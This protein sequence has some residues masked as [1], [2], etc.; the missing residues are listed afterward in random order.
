MRRAGM[1]IFPFAFAGLIAASAALADATAQTS[2]ANVVVTSIPAGRL[3][4]ALLMLAAEADVSIAFDATLIGERRTRG[5]ATPVPLRQALDQLLSGTGLMYKFSAQGDVSVLAAPRPLE[6]LSAPPAVFD[7]SLSSDT[8]IVTGYR[9]GLD[10]AEARKRRYDGLVEVISADAVGKL[11]D[12][13][14]ADALDRLP[15]VYR[16][17]DQGEGRY[18]SLRGISEVL[19]KVTLNGVT[20]AAS[21]TDGRSG[22]AAPLD[23][24]S[25]SAVSDVE[26]HSVIT[27]D[28][29]PSAIGGLIDVRTPTAHDFQE[30]IAYLTAEIGAADSGEMRDIHAVRGAYSDTF[31]PDNAFGIYVG[32]EHWVREYLS[33]FYDNAEVVPSS[34]GTAGLYPDRVIL[35]ASS[36]RR[37]RTSLTAALD[38]RGSDEDA[39]WF[40]VFTADY[41]DEE[42]RPEFLLYRRDALSASAPD[43]FSW[44]GVRVR[45]ETRHELQERP[46]RQYV[47]GGRWTLNDD[48]TLE[49]S[50]NRTSAEERN[51]LLNYYETLGD[52]DPL[53]AAS[54]DIGRF[55]IVDGRA[56]P[57][58]DLAAADGRSIF[59]GSFQKLFR[60]RR[61]TSE[62]REDIDTQQVDLHRQGFIGETPLSIQFGAK[63]LSRVKSVDDADNRY[64]FTGSETLA[65]PALGRSISDYRWGGPYPLV[66][67]V[68]FS[69]GNPAGLEALFSSRPDLFVFD[70]MSSRANSVEDDY[71]IRETIWSGYAMASLDLTSALR[72]TL[73]A[74]VERTNVHATA[75]AF[76]AS[77]SASGFNPGDNPSASLPFAQNDILPTSGERSYTN[78]SP[79]VLAKWDDGGDWVFRASLTH[80]FAR[81]DYVDLAPISTLSVSVT[82]DPATAAPVFNAMNET[83]NPMLRPIESQN[84]DVSGQYNLPGGLGWLSLAGFYKSLDSLLFEME[85]QGANVAFAGARFDSYTTVTMSNVGHGHVSGIEM[86]GRYDFLD[87]PAPFDGF[88]IL[89]NAA[90][91]DSSIST[92]TLPGSRPLVNQADLIYATQLYYEAD[93]FQ[94]RLAYD[95]QG[96]AARSHEWS[97]PTGNNFR[98][99]LSR[100]DLKIIVDL[101]DNW[102]ATLSGTN[103]TNTA[104]RNNRSTDPQLVGTGPG[105]EIYGREYRL[106]LTR[107]W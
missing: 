12:A 100:L 33:P 83:G 27:P 35:G 30:R 67:D 86:G 4:D 52:I 37:E 22:R 41:N 36:G 6:P 44:R 58:G 53:N 105:Y 1:R 63:H 40:R 106:S 15:S 17:S 18:L 10:R 72:L 75:N 94:A 26:I 39:L 31:G 47:L 21:D 32:G 70:A 78:V 97:T 107:R 46:V 54:P 20:I 79:A 103:L 11:P 28:R 81:P 82:R 49:A 104:F 89:A 38:W 64:N 84:W 57:D 92:P 61:I 7:P 102:R 34:S 74:R 23:V 59:D 60:I 25:A 29:D 71:R 56:T 65:N 13:N 5:V 96:R 2:R 14:I 85:E 93:G 99:P 101:D 48:W 45:T 8:V 50:I 16:I 51:P 19:D 68:D 55:R 42:V 73:G 87:A 43:A 69:F 77:V 88:G 98:E 9:D 95:Y 76:V 80:T 66:P 24:L 90:F 62:V 3:D 91:I